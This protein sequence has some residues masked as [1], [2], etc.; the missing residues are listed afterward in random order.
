VSAKYAPFID[1]IVKLSGMSASYV[2]E[3]GCGPAN[4][5]RIVANKLLLTGGG[6]SHVLTDL[7][8]DVLDLARENVNT[9]DCHHNV[10]E[11]IPHDLLSSDYS[12]ITRRKPTLIHG[13]GVLEHFDDDE[14]Q[15]ILEKQRMTAPNVIHY[16]PTDRYDKP[17]FGDERLMSVE[18]WVRIAKP[19]FKETFNDGH[20]L[21]LGWSRR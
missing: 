1:M 17:S 12:L 11:F 13:H 14:I 3:M 16:V 15:Y 9:T 20:D 19:N 8:H 7:H 5:S 2:A 4:V 18:D 21:M 10:F 6:K